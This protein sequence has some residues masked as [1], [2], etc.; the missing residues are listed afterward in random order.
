MK[1]A[2]T[3]SHGVGKTT[4]FNNYRLLQE[5]GLLEDYVFLDETPRK[6]VKQ[7]GKRID[8]MD[9]EEFWE[10]EEQLYEEQVQKETQVNN[11]ISDR[12][13]LDIVAY[14]DFYFMDRFEKEFLEK[15][16][17]EYKFIYVP[18]A[19]E[20]HPDEETRNNSDENYQSLIDQRIYQ[21][22][23]DYNLFFKIKE[24]ENG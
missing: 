9:E 7:K 24:G 19:F 13:L 16:Q 21:L 23:N 18:V 20:L 22:L 15:Y 11:F 8:E 4:I 5:M 10:F 3:G 12:C 1:I 6:I 14:S 2:I 17:K